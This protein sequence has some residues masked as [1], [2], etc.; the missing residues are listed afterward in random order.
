MRGG[1]EAKAT[2]PQPLLGRGAPSD[3]GGESL[4]RDPKPGD[5]AVGRAKPGQP[6]GGGP[7]GSCDRAVL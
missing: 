6:P 7:K 3:K 5:L 2:S 4:S 1:A